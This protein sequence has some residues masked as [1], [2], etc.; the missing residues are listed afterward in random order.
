[1]SGARARARTPTA[2]RL[3][4][5]A[6]RPPSRRRVH[7]YVAFLSPPLRHVFVVRGLP[8]R[9]GHAHD[10]DPDSD[11]DPVVR[12]DPRRPCLLGGL[13][14][15]YLVVHWSSLLCLVVFFFWWF[16]S[17]LL[18]RCR[19]SWLE[20]RAGCCCF[21]PAARSLVLGQIQSKSKVVISLVF[22]A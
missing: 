10:F 8:L 11:P 4:A 19:S 14:L 18:W 1:M 20:A 21:Q 6:R 13:N 15:L 3:R 12:A 17:S 7:R 2:V 5:V 16:E 22:V 9:H